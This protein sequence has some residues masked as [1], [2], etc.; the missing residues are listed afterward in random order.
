MF[1]FIWNAIYFHN[2]LTIP[3]TNH[4]IFICQHYEILLLC[5]STSMYYM[6]ELQMCMKNKFKN[7]YFGSIFKIHVFNNMHSLHIFLKT[8]YS[9]WLQIV[10]INLHFNFT[11]HKPFE[12]P[13]DLHTYIVCSGMILSVSWVIYLFVWSPEIK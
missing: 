3:C 13:S 9:D 11:F 4:I 8:L 12:V 10:C 7:T 6:H 5:M 2:V 1:Y